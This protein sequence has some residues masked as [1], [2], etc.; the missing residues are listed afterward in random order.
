MS[1]PAGILVVAAQRELR[2]ALFDTFD[3]DGQ[4][5]VHSARD[6]THAGILL[7][8]RAAL[9]LI[10]VVFDGDGRDTVAGIEVLRSLPACAKAPLIAVL[11]DGAVL[12]PAVLPAGVT[13]WLYASQ[14]EQEML[15][16]WQRLQRATRDGAHGERAASDGDY[17]FA[18]D[19]VDSE[20][21]IVD[22]ARGRI[23]EYS[24][25]V[26]RNSGL[27]D[28]ELRGRPL[29]DIL[30]FAEMGAEQVL[31]EGSR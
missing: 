6:A 12:K 21:L 13:D 16:R 14:I 23:L 30:A 26:A 31:A 10:V 3:H 8:G 27:G 22:S 7:E 19:E 18:F 15:A 2:R 1:G 25:A 5:V 24:S 4:F 29:Q 9:A 28:H 20:W 17:R 11:D